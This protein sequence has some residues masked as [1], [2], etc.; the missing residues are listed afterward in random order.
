VED[1]GAAARGG[2][3]ASPFPCLTWSKYSVMI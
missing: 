3:H 1:G 2:P